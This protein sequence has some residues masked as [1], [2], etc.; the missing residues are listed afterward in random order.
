MNKTHNCTPA[1][2]VVGPLPCKLFS[3]QD[4]W[5]KLFSLKSNRTKSLLNYFQ[6]HQKY[7]SLRVAGSEKGFSRLFWG[8]LAHYRREVWVWTSVLGANHEGL[9][10]LWHIFDKYFSTT[11]SNKSLVDAI[12]FKP[13]WKSSLW[14][15]FCY[16][17]P[18]LL[19]VL[20]ILRFPKLLNISLPNQ[21]RL[22]SA[23]GVCA[24]HQNS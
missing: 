12:F 17:F 13:A 4:K 1:R 11:F 23:Q 9:V 6:S 18:R 19:E 2:T 15:Y 22:Q 3:Y 10:W 8:E 7:P 24:A 16:T 14:K 21:Q 5:I 20:K